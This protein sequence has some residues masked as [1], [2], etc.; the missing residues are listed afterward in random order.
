MAVHKEV[1]MQRGPKPTP[2]ALRLVRGN[3]GKRPL[4]TDEPKPRPQI[5]AC[6]RHLNGP[7]RTEWKRISVELARMGLVTQLDR[8]ALAAY[9]VAWGRWLQ[10]ENRLKRQGAVVKTVNG[11]EIQNPYLAIANRAMAQ[12]KEFLLEFGMTPSARTRVTSAK[13]EDTADGKAKFFQPHTAG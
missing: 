12:M 9:C 13:A 11:N 2:T 1:L 8:A 6:P 5:P 10:A 4:P 3:P 7:A